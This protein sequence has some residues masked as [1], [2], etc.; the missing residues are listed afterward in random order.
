MRTDTAGAK[1]L[2]AHG[3]INLEADMVQ[4]KA[5]RWAGRLFVGVLLALPAILPVGC[6]MGRAPV[7]GVARGTGES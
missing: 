7:S 4:L 5:K 1:L 3:S 6:A 2:N